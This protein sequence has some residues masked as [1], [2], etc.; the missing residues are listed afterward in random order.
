MLEINVLK[1]L[2]WFP[3]VLSIIITIVFIGYCYRAIKAYY[4]KEEQEKVC[5]KHLVSFQDLIEEAL[6]ILHYFHNATK[7]GDFDFIKSNVLPEFFTVVEKRFCQGSVFSTSHFTKMIAEIIS[8]N[9]SKGVSTIVVRYNGFVKETEGSNYK[10]FQEYWHFVDNKT[11]GWVLSN[12]TQNYKNNKP[13]T[14][15]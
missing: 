11:N 5:E 12:I 13:V 4:K 7:Y 1:I 9:Y 6:T 15:D 3:I 10:P 8:V 14:G 2:S